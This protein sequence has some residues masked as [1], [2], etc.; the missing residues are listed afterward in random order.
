MLCSLSQAHGEDEPSACFR[1]EGG[2]S[3]DCSANCREHLTNE[4]VS[5]DT[6]KAPAIVAAIATISLLSVKSDDLPPFMISGG[7]PPLP[8]AFL[9]ASVNGFS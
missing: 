7:I 4:D 8:D 5:H 3:L 2:E 9:Q 6:E 1:K